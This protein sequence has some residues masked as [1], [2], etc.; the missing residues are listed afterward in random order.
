MS[1]II[2][3]LIFLLF[4]ALT[5]SYGIFG[6]GGLIAFVFGSLFLIDTN[7]ALFRVNQCLL[8][9][10]PCL[11]FVFLVRYTHGGESL[12]RLVL[13]GWWIDW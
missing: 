13:Q 2:L 8:A 7:T 6:I 5:P 10:S 4:E 11:I 12:K 9:V 1:L 3:G